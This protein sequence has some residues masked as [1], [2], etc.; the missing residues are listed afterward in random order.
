MANAQ[1]AFHVLY[2]AHRVACKCYSVQFMD[3]LCASRGLAQAR[4]ILWRLWWQWIRASAAVGGP[5]T[6]LIDPDASDE[7]RRNMHVFGYRLIGA[8]LAPTGSDK[9]NKKSDVP[10]PPPALHTAALYEVAW[11]FLRNHAKLLVRSDTAA[12]SVLPDFVAREEVPRNEAARK[13][14]A[15]DWHTL[16]LGLTL[17][18]QQSMQRNKNTSNGSDM[19]HFIAPPYMIEN[20]ERLYFAGAL[21]RTLECEVGNA[22]TRSLWTETLTKARPLDT[23]PMIAQRNTA[24][25]LFVNILNIAAAGQP[26]LQ[27][28]L[29][30]SAAPQ[31]DI[32][33]PRFSEDVPR[34]TLETHSI[35]PALAEVAN[36]AI[37]DAE[38]KLKKARARKKDVGVKTDI[39]MRPASTALPNIGE[40]AQQQQQRDNINTT[41]SNPRETAAEGSTGTAGQPVNYSF[42]TT[43]FER[44]HARTDSMSP[45]GSVPLTR[46]SDAGGTGSP[47][48][49][50]GMGTSRS[51]AR[52]PDIAA[53]NTTVPAPVLARTSS[54]DRPRVLSRAK[55]RSRS[56]ADI[57]VLRHAIADKER[58]A[59]SDEDT[60]EHDGTDDDEE[61]N[62][63]SSSTSA[64]TTTTNGAFPARKVEPQPLQT[65]LDAVAYVRGL[66]DTTVEWFREHSY[67]IQN[68]GVIELL[69][70]FTTQTIAGERVGLH[71][72]LVELC[73]RV[74]PVPPDLTDFDTLDAL[75]RAADRILEDS[76]DALVRDSELTTAAKYP[77][78][79]AARAMTDL[80]YALV[81]D[82]VLARLLIKH[83]M[84]MA[85]ESENRTLRDY[86]HTHETRAWQEK[87]RDLVALF[88]GVFEQLSRAFFGPGRVAAPPPP[89]ISMPP[90]PRSPASPVV[91]PVTTNNNNINGAFPTAITPRGT[92]NT[93]PRRG[94]YMG[95]AR[96]TSAPQIEETI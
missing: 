72:W 32:S 70:R 96:S 50:P 81:R 2:C 80:E 61:D 30:T 63:E 5:A 76:M 84:A 60:S 65:R 8:D 53:L 37:K 91:P 85:Y 57:S 93:T 89:P 20:T 26:A 62:H 94:L 47:R 46:K 13:A 64:T 10:S 12:S 7:L 59:L 25:R 15:A 86:D 23:H 9:D 78:R 52:V 24:E 18:F 42:E 31:L 19:E 48:S 35:D 36:A 73:Q 74:T 16:E 88:K 95:M 83:L 27:A 71:A 34:S 4:L 79:D 28:H 29:A 92:G 3:D 14:L 6:M 45:R 38:E 43:T 82:I 11:M 90:L 66:V 75:T 44:T 67:T 51:A 87:L 69:T 77:T 56:Y 22:A 41:N 55:R 33:G 39:S 1:T 21:V 49:M 54:G 68:E 17:R 40:A 58:G